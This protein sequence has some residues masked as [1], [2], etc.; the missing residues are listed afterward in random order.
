MSQ[1][2][3]LS[4]M[5]LYQAAATVEYPEYISAD[6]PHNECPA[7]T[8][9]YQMGRASVLELWGMWRTPSLSLLLGLLWPGLVVPGSVPSMCQIELFN[10]LQS[11]KQFTCVQRNN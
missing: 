8:Q 1:S 6:R 2:I 11:L 5:Q 3:A 7:M 4:T 10:H 9:N